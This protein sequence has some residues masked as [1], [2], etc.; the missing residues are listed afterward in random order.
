M[1]K[2]TIVGKNALVIAGVGKEEMAAQ[3]FNYEQVR[4]VRLDMVNL[5]VKLLMSYDE[6][7]FRVFSINAPTNTEEEKTKAKST[8]L[9]FYNDLVNASMRMTKEEM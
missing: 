8:V 4:E 3:V 6:S 9:R 5:E 2:R 1:N 7:Y